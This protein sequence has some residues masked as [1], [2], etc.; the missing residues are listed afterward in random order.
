[1]VHAMFRVG[2]GGVGWGGEIGRRFLFCLLLMPV[3]AI[4]ADDT[5]DHRYIL[6]RSDGEVIM[7]HCGQSFFAP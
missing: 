5:T 1:M 3:V 7:L 2:S 4:E 6:L